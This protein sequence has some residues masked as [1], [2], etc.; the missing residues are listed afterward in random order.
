MRFGPACLV[1]LAACGSSGGN[2]PPPVPEIDAAPGEFSK[3]ELLIAA[4]DCVVAQLDDFQTAA[5]ALRVAAEAHAAD[6]EQRPALEAAWKAAMNSWEIAELYQVGPAAL[7]ANEP[8]GLDLRDQI[9]AWPLTS[10]CKIDEQLVSKAYEKETFPTSVIS[11]R[12]LG[13]IEYLVFYTGSENA[14][15]S[16]S[17]INAGGETSPWKMLSAAELAARRAAYAVAVAK[18]VE[19][20][21]GELVAAWADGGGGFR[22]ALVDAGN[23]STLFSSTQAGLNAIT[24]AFFYLDKQVKDGKIAVP[25]G[26]SM[27]G[28]GE[29]ICPDAVESRYA[30]VSLAH[31]QN[32]LLGFERLFAGCSGPDA[33]GFD[34][35]LIAAKAPGLAAD[36]LAATADARAALA[37]ITPSFEEVLASDHEQLRAVHA[38]VKVITD[39]LKA[40]FVTTLDL[41]LPASVESDND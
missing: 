14:C 25:A 12:G 10:A 40:D 1:L 15:G 23:G 17:P 5:T 27:T 19:G 36:L 28:C 26:M 21:A 13:A 37:A 8:G 35:W 16:F 34:D 24:N 38:K 30:R 32:N 4:A 39:L 9:Y 11:G 18:V 6:A 31:L 33:L 41:E 20:K 7:K 2:P 3:R 29:T 22:K